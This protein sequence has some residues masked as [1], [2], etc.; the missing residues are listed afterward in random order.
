MTVVDKTHHCLSSGHVCSVELVK[1]LGCGR[2]NNPRTAPMGSAAGVNVD[3][4]PRCGVVFPFFP[5][6]FT[7]P[8]A[9]EA[10]RGGEQ[11]GRLRLDEEVL[12]QPVLGVGGTQEEQ[13]R[14][15]LA[16]CTS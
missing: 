14:E 12:E 10:A 4:S 2:R 16:L 11:E 13:G 7:S 15:R 8:S 5:S 6:R 9:A 1:G 3:S